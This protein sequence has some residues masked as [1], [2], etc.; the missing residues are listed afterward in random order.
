ME[1][2][3]KKFEEIFKDDLEFMQ[4]LKEQEEDETELTFTDYTMINA[5]ALSSYTILADK[6]SSFMKESLDSKKNIDEVTTS[7]N[8]TMKIINY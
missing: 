7:L 8:D 1:D 5:L 6:L 4:N 2:F 3:T